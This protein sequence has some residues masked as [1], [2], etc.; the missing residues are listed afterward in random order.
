MQAAYNALLLALPFFSD[1]RKTEI[2]TLL[3]A[4]K[5][6]TLGWREVEF[7]EASNCQTGQI[8]TLIT[9]GDEEQVRYFI[10]DAAP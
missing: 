9:D 3:A 4:V 6:D 5:R 10:K 1:K 7:V 8:R 2:Q